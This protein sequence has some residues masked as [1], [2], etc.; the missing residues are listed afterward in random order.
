M[1]F[2]SDDFEMYVEPFIIVLD[3][4]G[5]MIDAVSQ[6]GEILPENDLHAKCVEFWDIDI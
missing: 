1:S 6:V 5:L 3:L 4:S 2:I